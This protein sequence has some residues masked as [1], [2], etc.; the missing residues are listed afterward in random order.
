MSGDS[1]YV[2]MNPSESNNFLSK[3]TFRVSPRLKISAQSIMSKSQGKSYAHAY[4][5]NPDGIATGYTANN[6]HSLQINHSISAK[7]FY[8]GNIF[9]SDTDYKNYLYEDTLDVRY[10]NTDYINTEP[11]SATFLFG[12]TQMGHTYR[13][14]KSIGGKFD[15]TSQ[16]SSNHEIKTGFSFRNDNLVERNLQV[17]YNQNYDEPTV[18]KENRS[19]Y[20]I[21]YDKDAVQYSAYIQDKMEYSSMIMNIGVRYDAFIPNDSTIANL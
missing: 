3:F 6:N 7:S 18:L 19:P 11:T 13:V 20:H 8:E 5:Y 9:F 1:S 17:L 14:S 10:V 16:I 2:P 12:G 4:K 21:F 15:F